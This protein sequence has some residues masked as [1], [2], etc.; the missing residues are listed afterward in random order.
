[1]TSSKM[2]PLFTR[3]ARRRALVLGAL[4]L[5]VLGPL[6]SFLFRYLPER[7]GT[8][9]ISLETDAARSLPKALRLNMMR[10]TKLQFSGSLINR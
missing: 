10:I 7:V 3:F 8:I 4:V 2:R 9:I 1:M 5:I 6:L